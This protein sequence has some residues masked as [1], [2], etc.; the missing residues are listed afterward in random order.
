MSKALP[1]ENAKPPAAGLLDL[2]WAQLTSRPARHLL[3]AAAECRPGSP[4]PHRLLQRATR[5]EP[6]AYGAAVD[7][8]VSL[9]WLQSHGDGP[10]IAAPVADHARRAAQRHGLPSLLP[11]VTRAAIH[12]TTEALLEGIGLD[13]EGDG[14]DQPALPAGLLALGH[15]LQ[16][17]RLEGTAATLFDVQ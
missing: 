3:L 16:A 17:L 4:I 6:G 14:L 7:L 1:L 5:L 12:L 11:A 13:T 9:G 2:R 10:I 15:E 8:L